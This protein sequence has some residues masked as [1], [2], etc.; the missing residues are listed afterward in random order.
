[1]TEA[2]DTKA[3][4]ALR[5]VDL[6]KFLEQIKA[7]GSWRQWLN[8][9]NELHIAKICKYRGAAEGQGKA[10]DSTCFRGGKWAESYKEDFNKW[11]KSQLAGGFD[12]QDT[13]LL[14]NQLRTV[15]TLPPGLSFDGLSGEM[16]NFIK[17]NLAEIKRQKDK[18]KELQSRLDAKE[19][20]V[21]ELETELCSIVE[22][23]KSSDEHFLF[24][25]R[26]LHYD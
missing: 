7:D 2:I 5:E 12:A 15:T 1:M 19:R 8:P 16:V 23:V 13:D 18:V 11:V 14:G 4:K 10:W 3:Q 25:A 9:S 24:C 21:L 6:V 17:D 20:K 26:T 22:S